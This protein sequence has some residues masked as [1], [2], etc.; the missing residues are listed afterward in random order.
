MKK[1][2]LLTLMNVEREQTKLALLECIT[3]TRNT[4]N[5]IEQKLHDQETLYQSDG[6]QG[7]ADK[8]DV[9][10]AKLQYINVTIKRVLGE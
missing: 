3:S 5:S 8:I 6:L 1:E 2:Q 4:L 9:Y 7:N 10:I